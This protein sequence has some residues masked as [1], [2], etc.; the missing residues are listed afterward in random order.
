MPDAFSPG[1]RFGFEVRVRPTIRQH[2]DGDRTRSRERDAFLAAIEK[3][4]PR[5]NRAELDRGAVYTQWLARHFETGGAKLLDARA[6]ALRRT[7]VSRRN[8]ERRLKSDIE[9]PD[10]TLV[11]TLEIAQPEAFLRFLARGVGRHR[12]FGFGMLLLK[13]IGRM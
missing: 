13:P 4:G 9:G 10:A 5:P 11:G 2:I 3:A 7:R 8:G 12:A 1:Q 6:A